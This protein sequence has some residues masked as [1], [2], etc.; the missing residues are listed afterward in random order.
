MVMT[1]D[2]AVI[3][4]GAIGLFLISR[5]EQNAPTQKCNVSELLLR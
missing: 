5:I 3:P 2:I 4:C 1:S